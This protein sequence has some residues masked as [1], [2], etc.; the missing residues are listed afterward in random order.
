MKT[1]IILLFS[2]AAI[3]GCSGTSTYRELESVDSLMDSDDLDSISEAFKSVVITDVN[4]VDKDFMAYY[5]MLR[6]QLVFRFGKIPANDSLIDNSIDYYTQMKDNEKLARSYYYKGRILYKR[7]K[8][9]DATYCLKKAEE[10]A[11]RIDNYL[12]ISRIKYNLAD[13]NIDGGETKKAIDYSMQAIKYAE[14]SGD[15][16]QLLNSLNALSCTYGRLEIDDSAKFYKNKY[17]PLIKYIPEKSRAT[18]LANMAC[19]YNDIGIDKAKQYVFQS[20]RIKEK[21]STY[22]V[23]ADIYLAEKNY[24]EAEKSWKRGLEICGNDLHLEI[25]LLNDMREYKHSIGESAE[26][27]LLSDKV[28][29]LS[30]SLQRKWENDSIKAIQDWFASQQ[31]QKASEEKADNIRFMSVVVV[32]LLAVVLFCVI[33]YNVRKRRKAR[34]IIAEQQERMAEQ[35]EHITIQQTQLSEKQEQIIE[36]QTQLSDY[37]KT[38]AATA[39]KIEKLSAKEQE[40]KRIADNLRRNMKYMEERHTHELDAV[41]EQVSERL[42][43]G[44]NLW[45]S[46]NDGGKILTWTKDD[47]DLFI[48]YYKTIKPGFDYHPGL[49]STM[50]IYLI[51]IDMGKSEDEVMTIMGLTVN[52]LRTMKS[53]IKNCK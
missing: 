32:L 49:S 29:M 30:D 41:R 14:L 51:L 43:A 2:L 46:V 21:A 53:R 26:A 16:E 4:A 18:F 1:L 47:R 15:M 24:V 50:I 22:R 7:G 3:L 40:R 10:Y 48:E 37:E 23:L 42:S 11:K 8:V 27:A 19:D 39:R 25:N 34:Q 6:Y 28:I 12:L 31:A 13:F 9:K 17:I 5:N 36:Q 44:H 52:S 35:E 38:V 20:L 45:Q 33:C